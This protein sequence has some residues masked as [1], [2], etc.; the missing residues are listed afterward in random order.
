MHEIIVLERSGTFQHYF[1]QV[2]LRD[3]YRIETLGTA[4]GMGAEIKKYRSS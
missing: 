1:V 3:I 2:G 4:T